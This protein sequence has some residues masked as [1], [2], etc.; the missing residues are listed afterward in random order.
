MGRNAHD[1][2]DADRVSRPDHL[3][4][5]LKPKGSMLAVYVNKVVSNSPGR[6]DDLGCPHLNR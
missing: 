4:S 1:W 2:G 3:G 6:F 5:T